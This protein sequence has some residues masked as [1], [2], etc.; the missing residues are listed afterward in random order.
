[1]SVI[2]SVMSSKGGTSKTTFT[3][4]ASYE[5]SK[6]FKVCI[7]DT[8]PQN[9]IKNIMDNRDIVNLS[10][11][12]DTVTILDK[13]LAKIES[14]RKKYDYIFVDTPPVI[15][16]NYTDVLIR[17]SDYIVIPCKL[18][19]IDYLSNKNIVDLAKV[20]NKQAKIL[21]TQAEY[22]QNKMLFEF[23]K[24]FDIPFFSTTFSKSSDAIKSIN[25]FKTLDEIKSKKVAEIQLILK[26]LL[27]DLLNDKRLNEGMIK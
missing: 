23:K 10:P 5:L 20:F 8:D 4:F 15:S 13:D 24:S 12:C 18:S 1:M 14:L 7:V 27:S 3:Y 21:I 16:E 22:Y 25:E 19:I 6:L 26:E 17:M 11:F 2:I 9:S